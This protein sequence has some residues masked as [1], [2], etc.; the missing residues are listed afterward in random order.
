M[1]HTQAWMFLPLASLLCG[2]DAALKQQPHRSAAVV[3]A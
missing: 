1:H 2:P 3:E